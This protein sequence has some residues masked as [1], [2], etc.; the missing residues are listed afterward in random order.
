MK[1]TTE[2]KE[3]MDKNS[4]KLKEFKQKYDDLIKSYTDGYTQKTERAII[5]LD[6]D[7]KKHETFAAWLIN[8]YKHALSAEIMP[9]I[10]NAMC[11]YAG[12]KYGTRTAEKIRDEIF[13]KTNKTISFWIDR[14]FDQSSDTINITNLMFACPVSISIWTKGG[15]ITTRENVININALDAWKVIGIAPYIDDFP[16]AYMDMQT[17]R[18]AYEAAEKAR[19]EAAKKYNQYACECIKKLT[20]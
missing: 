8:N 18:A 11:K 19:E 3:E 5:E 2:L 10:H 7:I 4:E 6:Q 15:D 13:E 9:I 12:K 1:T 20:Y 16:A 14:R 17:A